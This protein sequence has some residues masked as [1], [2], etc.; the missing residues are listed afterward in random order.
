MT[1]ETTNEN[2]EHAL[3]ARSIARLRARVMAAVFATVSAAA[4]FV[5][6][7]WLV[8]RGGEQVGL[9]LGLIRNYF[10]GY[11]VTWGG[12]CIGALYAG[13]I[14]MILGWAMA[15]IY[16]SISGRANRA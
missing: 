2:L 1:E 13:A 7:A 12:A 11:S 5:A 4:L 3:F 6:T 15:F 8:I 9:H 10:P 16:N 14:G